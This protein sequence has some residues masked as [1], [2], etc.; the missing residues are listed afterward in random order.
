MLAFVIWLLVGRVA[1]HLKE[2]LIAPVEPGGEACSLLTSQVIP[3]FEMASNLEAMASNLIANYT[4]LPFLFFLWTCFPFSL[5][6]LDIFR[7]FFLSF[8]C[9]YK[10]FYA[11]ICTSVPSLSLLTFEEP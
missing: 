3:F 10:C 1:N 4:F 2:R 9:I 6:S 5:Y 8:L 11:L 7:P